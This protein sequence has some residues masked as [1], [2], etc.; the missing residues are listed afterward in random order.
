MSLK[1]KIKNQ[2]DIPSRIKTNTDDVNLKQKGEFL[3]I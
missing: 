3:V 2:R 1:L